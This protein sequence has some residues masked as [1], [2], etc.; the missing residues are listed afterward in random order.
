MTE[1]EK[2][3]GMVRRA[4]GQVVDVPEAWVLANDPPRKPANPFDNN[5]RSRQSK[6]FTG[7]DCLAGQT[8][9]FDEGELR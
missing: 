6:L 7:L 1:S 5:D 9:L 8:D 3:L 4:G 2:L